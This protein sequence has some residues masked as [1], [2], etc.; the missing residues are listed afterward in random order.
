MTFFRSRSSRRPPLPSD[1]ISSA[2][3]LRAA[4]T[5]HPTPPQPNTHG[6]TSPGEGKTKEHSWGLP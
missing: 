5:A 4:T 2:A 3:L 1:T 6:Q